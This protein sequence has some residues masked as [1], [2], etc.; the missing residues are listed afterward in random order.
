[1]NSYRQQIVILACAL[2]LVGN[3]LGR[4]QDS[5]SLDRQAVYR[6]Q[7]GLEETTLERVPP[8]EVKPG[9]AYNYYHPGL[10]QRVW[11]IAEGKGE[12]RYAFGEGTILPTEG[13]DLRI[14]EALKNEILERNAPGLRK[15]L[16]STGDS[17]SVRLDAE[18][19][20][21]LVR[22]KSGVRI[23]DI[24]SGKRWEWHGRSRKA[25]L[26]TH[27]DRWQ[28]VSGRYVPASSWMASCSLGCSHVRAGSAVLVMRSPE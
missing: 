15:A 23:F 7:P 4:A 2:L 3:E 1:M 13:L 17:P 12:F 16:E 5:D 21:R 9:L 27:G 6:V 22:A 25:V 8:A 28:V 19:R 11:G 14:S 24:A 26:H 20:W 10:G 18:G